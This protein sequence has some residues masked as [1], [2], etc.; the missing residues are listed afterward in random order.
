MVTEMEKWWSYLLRGLLALVFGIA[1]LVWPSATVLVLIVFFGCY[2][3]VEGCF[4]LG[5]AIAR[6]MRKEK[7]FGLLMLGVLGIAVGIITLARPGVTTVALA[8][9]IAFWLVIKGFAM[10]I[11]AVE[12][13]GS[14]GL[15]WAIGLIGG[16]SVIL[17]V[18]V[19]AVPFRSVVA[20]VLL[21]GIFS[22]FAA[23]MQF[24][25]SYM[26]RK[27]EKEEGISPAIV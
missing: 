5:Y 23:I 27:L 16:I 20:V 3:L 15:R 26:A 12:M 1:V 6:A 7:F 24:I 11:G 19:F 21:I 4:A 18:V 10:I 9:V 8:Y 14:K 25:V 2:V 22:I 13:T 17:G